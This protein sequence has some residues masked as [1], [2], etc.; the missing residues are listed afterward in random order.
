MINYSF[1]TN[2]KCEGCVDKVK[3]KLDQL[4]PSKDIDKWEVNLE[5]AEKTLSVET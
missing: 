2:F 4:Q 5:S 3:P 1:K